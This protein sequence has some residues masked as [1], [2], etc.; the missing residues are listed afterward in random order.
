MDLLSFALPRRFLRGAAG[1]LALTVLALAAAVALICAID[2]VNRAVVRSFAEVVDAMAGRAALTITAAGAP[3]P[4]HIAE[5]VAAVPGVAL[6]VPA[7]A[8]SALIADDSGELL[9]IHG[10]DITNDTA[11]R[12]YESR[13]RDGTGLADP[14]EFLNQLDSIIVTRALAARRRLAIGDPL[15]LLTPSGR[16]RFTI[17]GLLEPQGIGRVYGGNLVIMDVAAAAAAFLRPE[18]INRVDVVA[19]PTASLDAVAATIAARL[20]PGYRVERPAQRKA[21]LQRVIRSLQL[22]LDAV[23]LIG[24][25]AAFLII[26]NRLTGV[27]EARAWQL[28]VLRAVGLRA[29]RVWWEVL[30]ESI[31]VSALGVAL[32]IPLGIAIGR[33][34]LPVVAATAALNFKLVAAEPVLS[35]RLASLF[36][37]TAVGIGTAVVAAAVPAWHIAR[38]PPVDAIRTRGLAIARSRRVGVLLRIVTGIGIALTVTLQCTGA[39][40]AWGL[41]ATGL[42]FVGTALCARPLLALAAPPL[43]R[44]CRACAGPS[45]NVARGTLTANAQRAVL[46]IAMIA[47]GIGAVV[48]LRM[49]AWSFEA[50]L[51]HALSGALQGDW[52]VSAAH[53]AQGFLEA[54]I[55]DRILAELGAVDGVGA[56]TGERLIDWEFG[57]GP[58]AIDAFDEQYFTTGAFGSWPL[59]G[60]TIPDVASAVA[61]G[62]AV[63]VSGDL[64]VRVGD[65]IELRTPNG[66]LAMRVGGVTIDF[67]SPRGTLVVARAL[68]RRYW[69]D[70]TVNRVFVRVRTGA[71]P[72]AVRDAIVRQLGR[73]YELRVISASALLEYF[74]AQTRRAFGPVDVLT[75]LI[76]AVLLVGLADALAAN[77]LERTSELATIRAL[78]GRRGFV[79]TAVVMEAVA[80]AMPGIALAVAAGSTLGWLWV[81]HTFPALLGWPLETYVPYTHLAGVAMATIAVCAVAALVPAQRAARLEIATALRCD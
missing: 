9:T 33:L 46:T 24:V 72:V 78:G 18:L 54:P 56:T 14:L 61:S 70:F 4:E 45:A 32:G 20:P 76:L 23:A 69:A 25:G 55:D 75:A 1:R 67:G 2:L 42:I 74:S 71:D 21:D 63:L 39:A 16:K 60:A 44:V 48:W 11:V 53:A 41:A 66:P 34:L 27:F 51:V 35:I 22:M 13:D 28:G 81:R 58:I 17:R 77:V 6:A 64:G 68:L 62:T 40:P 12:V 57:G 8:A 49:V 29:R 79:R 47:V 7:V 36:V 5:T 52:V 80:V 31:A 37:A 3:F 10:V 59:I 50:S 38:R 65:T 26:L 43:M 30:K 15:E 73:T 19:A